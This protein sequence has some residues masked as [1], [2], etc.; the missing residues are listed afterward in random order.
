MDAIELV[1]GGF[2][3]LFLSFFF[4][5][6]PYSA[7][8]FQSAEFVNCPQLKKKYFLHCKITNL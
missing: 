2:F 1:S 8:F 5:Q 3:F 4:P 7:L 6:K